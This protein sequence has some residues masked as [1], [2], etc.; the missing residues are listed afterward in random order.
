MPLPSAPVPLPCIMRS[1][2][3]PHLA[4]FSRIPEDTIVRDA[5]AELKALITYVGRELKLIEEDA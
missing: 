1:S 4:A 5:P 3:G 2:V